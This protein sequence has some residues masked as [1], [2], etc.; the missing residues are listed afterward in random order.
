MD[1]RD[2]IP[3]PSQGNFH[4]IYYETANI[5][6]GSDISY[7]K[8]YTSL[9]YIYTFDNKH[10]FE[11][12]VVIGSADETLHYV[13]RFRWGGFHTFF[14]KRLNSLH[15]RMIVATNLGYRFKLSLQNMFETYV[16]F[17]WDLVNI[18]EKNRSV[19]FKDF[20]H[21][22]GVVVSMNLPVGPIKFGYGISFNDTD[23]IYFSLGH[24]F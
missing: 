2:R 3:F 14:G 18:V 12:R 5:F 21:G 1:T 9:G 7:V 24:H 20:K 8:F 6:L 11:P 22:V 13:T 15:G 4:E 19:R 17:R 16:G 23:R 10:T